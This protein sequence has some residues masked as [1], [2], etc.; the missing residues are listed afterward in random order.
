LSK[1]APLSHPERGTTNDD[2]TGGQ[3]LTGIAGSPEHPKFNFQR[4]LDVLGAEHINNERRLFASPIV[5][6]FPQ[7]KIEFDALNNQV[8]SGTPVVEL[9]ALF[10]LKPCS[11]LVDLLTQKNHIEFSGPNKTP[12]V[13][14]VPYMPCRKLRDKE[15]AFAFGI[16]TLKQLNLDRFVSRERIQEIKVICHIG[17]GANGTCCLGVSKTGASCCAIKFFH[18][19]QE[20]GVATNQSD[21]VEKE[22]ENWKNV[23]G[24]DEHLPQCF[25]WRCAS[26]SGSCLIM[27]YLKP[28]P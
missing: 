15:K 22:L 2:G 12:T 28:I 21:M 1:S 24:Q 8:T 23:Y 14:I 13:H 26:T 17:R 20:G 10:V 3:V 18:R 4:N 6:P 5:P 7:N 19:R 16:V 11:S 25:V 27:P 9:I